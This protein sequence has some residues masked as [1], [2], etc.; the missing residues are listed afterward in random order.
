MVVTKMTWT[1]ELKTKHCNVEGVRSQRTE[2]TLLERGPD[3]SNEQPPSR[4]RWRPLSR[5][6][7]ILF[8][9]NLVAY[10]TIIVAVFSTSRLV[11]LDWEVFNWRPY[12]HWPAL[13]NFLNYYVIAGQRGPVAI[14]VSGWLSWRCWRTRSWRPLLVLGV[15]LVL[16]NMSVGAVKIGTGR[17]GPHYAH[18]Y[19][20][21]EI[22]L[23][24]DIFP[25]GHTANAVVTWGVLAYLATRWRR[26]GAVLAGWT[27]ITVGATTVY[28]GT[29]WVTDVLAGWCAGALVLL[30]LPLFE[31]I[32]TSADERMRGYW[33]T[34]IA[35]WLRERFG[36]RGPFRGR[37]DEL[38]ELDLFPTH[39]DQIRKP[40]PVARDHREL[41]SRNS[42]SIPIVY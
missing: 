5:T 32:I 3:Q 17:L 1:S 29:H 8:A 4:E 19:G 24:G 14:V 34:G 26:T 36:G 31:P 41:A 15:A 2:G 42:R 35:P 9:V 40:V 16:L 22:F 27:A 38:D 20:S 6:H 30:I 18:V 11:A 12:E 10:A 7:K 23:G 39:S 37:R 21:N 13:W 25:S 28:L 33:T